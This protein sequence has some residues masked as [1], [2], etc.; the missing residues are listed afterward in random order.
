MPVIHDVTLTFSPDLPC[1]PGDPAPTVERINS[2]E[3]GASCNVTRLDSHVH[4]GT[5]VDAPVHFVDGAADVTTMP[6]DVLLGPAVVVDLPDADAVTAEILD[7]LDLDAGVQRLLFKTRNSDLW[8]D[9]AQGFRTDYVALT[10]DAARWVV[11]RD[12]R[13]VGVDYLSV[14]RFGEPGHATHHV[15]LEAAVIIVEGL[16]LRGID[17]GT[18]GLVCLP[19]KIA[20]ADGAPARVVLTV[21]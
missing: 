15:L 12:I 16:D 5:H 4:F 13:L 19:M 3:D 10:P 9:P 2:I 21:D 14:E 11:D 6:L 18:Y 20:G 17:G 8:N 7:G 1:W